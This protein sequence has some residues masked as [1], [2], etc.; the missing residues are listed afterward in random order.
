MLID[1]IEAIVLTL[2]AIGAAC[3]WLL[4]AIEIML[5]MIK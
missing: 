4:F 2:T 1:R 5:G 3:F